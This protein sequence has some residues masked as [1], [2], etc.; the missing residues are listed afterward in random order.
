VSALL[1]EAT[2]L[3]RS[4]SSNA[5]GTSPAP[6]PGAAPP[7]RPWFWQTWGG[8]RRRGAPLRAASLQRRG[9]SVRAGSVAAGGALDTASSLD[10]G[11]TVVRVHAGSPD[12]E[13]GGAGPSASG[14]PAG[15]A[16][17]SGRGGGSAAAMAAE[18]ELGRAGS[19]LQHR[20]GSHASAGKDGGGG[21][22]GGGGPGAGGPDDEDDGGGGADGDGAVRAAHAVAAKTFSALVRK[23]AAL[24]EEEEA[25]Q[26]KLAGKFGKGERR[27]SLRQGW[28]AGGRRALRVGGCD[29]EAAGLMLDRGVRPPPPPHT[30]RPPLAS[31]PARPV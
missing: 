31:G 30:P 27:H 15:S 3:N 22:P 26:L 10:A 8:A 23:Y 25:A 11:D 16:G 9:S 28:G 29:E 20:H 5:S 2:G 13:Q 1:T 7:P 21:G 18:L 14:S 24:S 17:G 19:I 12:E 6:P 4:G